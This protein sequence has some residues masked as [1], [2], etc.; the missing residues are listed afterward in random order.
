MDVQLLIGN[1]D[2]SAANGAVFERREPISGAIA[3]RAA[4]ASVADA[5]AA[6]RVA[7]DAFP[8]WSQLGPNARRALLLKAADSIEQ[9]GEKAVEELGL[10][11]CNLEACRVQ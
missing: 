11:N 2:L 4:A 7:S 10:A 8:V 5:G 1:Q 6:V 9:L 3:T